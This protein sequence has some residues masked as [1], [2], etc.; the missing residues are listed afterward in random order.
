[1]DEDEGEDD[2]GGADAGAGF[3]KKDGDEEEERKASVDEE[4]ARFEFFF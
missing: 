1:M 3:C 2:E 4:V